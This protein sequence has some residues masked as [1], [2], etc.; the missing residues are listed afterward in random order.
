MPREYKVYNIPNTWGTLLISLFII[1]ASLRLRL[2]S[3]FSFLEFFNKDPRL[4]SLCSFSSKN[5]TG[6]AGARSKIKLSKQG[7]GDRCP[8]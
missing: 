3:N 2:N 7:S 8:R 1:S 6:Q 4:N 5:L